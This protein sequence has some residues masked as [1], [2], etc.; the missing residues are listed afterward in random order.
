MERFGKALAAALYAVAVIAVPLF[1]GDHRPGPSQWVQIVI[2]ALT[3]ATV[4][5]VPIVEGVPY[6]KSVVGALLAVAQIL[7]TVIDDG[8]SGTD[9]LTIA[10]AA[11]GALGIS[12]APADSSGVAGGAA[13]GWGADDKVAGA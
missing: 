1:S 7:V 2:A 3:A 6:I 13:V 12:L 9:M 11:L 5:L 8:V 4:Y 10:L